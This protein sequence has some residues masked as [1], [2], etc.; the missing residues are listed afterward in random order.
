MEQT[1]RFEKGLNFNILQ[2]HKLIT[3]VND[4]D[5][6]YTSIEELT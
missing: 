6:Q 4:S 5:Q 1:K 2:K 3:M